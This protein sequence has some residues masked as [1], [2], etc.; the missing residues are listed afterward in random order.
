MIERPVIRRWYPFRMIRLVLSVVCGCGLFA[1]V[2][3]PSPVAGEMAWAVWSPETY[4]CPRATT[5]IVIDGRLDDEAWSEIPW[6]RAFGDIEGDRRP[7]PRLGTRA[8]MA[9]DETYF[10]FAADMEEPDLWATYTERDSIIFH[11]NDFEV[12]I[13]PDDDTHLYAELEINALNTVWDLLLVRPYRNGG[14]ALHDWDIPGLRTAVDLRGTINNPTDRDSGWSV[15]IAIPFAALR[16]FAGTRCPPATGDRW[17]VNFSRVQWRIEPLGSGYTK[18][19]DSATDEPYSEDNWTWTPQRQIAMHEPE[20]WGF[21]EFREAGDADRPVEITGDDRAKFVLRHFV[22]T[23]D[24]WGRDAAMAMRR[25]PILSPGWSWPPEY[26]S[27]DGW[28]RATLLNADGRVLWL[29]RTGD[30]G[31]M[32]PADERAN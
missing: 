30:I 23:L 21:V 2:S 31:I 6:T 10:Y 5:P 4:A 26:V 25:P 22:Q 14:P 17:R 20:Y 16:P 13:D 11:E 18:Q 12:F 28:F 9:W 1:C 7:D 3:S 24:A 8:K 32:P 15:E 19:I 27:G 29:D